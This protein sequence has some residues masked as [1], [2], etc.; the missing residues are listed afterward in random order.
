M[1]SAPIGI[2]SAQVARLQS[3][4]DSMRA[5]GASESAIARLPKLPI[6]A[7]PFV[8]P[9]VVLAVRPGHYPPKR[10]M[11]DT[12]LR[13]SG[14]FAAPDQ[15]KAVRRTNTTNTEPEKMHRARAIAG[16]VAR[17]F[18][19]EPYQVLSGTRIRSLSNARKIA[20]L[21]IRDL[22]GF[23]YH[24]TSEVF[25]LNHEAARYLCEE[26]ASLLKI[27]QDVARRHAEALA[28]IRARWPEY[29]T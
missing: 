18:G 16:M 21:I 9:P 27:S 20:A 7:K 3:M 1:S 5:R 23:G 11:D 17:A 15:V 6:Y 28:A 25:D 10:I 14:R 2:Y 26:G 19:K 22:T 8:L 4:H 24:R 12:V 13:V 29:R